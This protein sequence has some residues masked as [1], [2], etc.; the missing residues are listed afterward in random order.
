MTNH[1]ARPLWT[2][3]APAT[4]VLAALSLVTP[5]QAAAQFGAVETLARRVSDLSFYYSRGGATPGGALDDDPVG[6]TSFGVEL[7]FE[8]ARIPSPAARRRRAT[9]RPADRRVL[10]EVEVVRGEDGAVDSIFHYDVVRS[11]PG[12]G[13][14]DILWTLELGI[15]YGQV[16]GLEL[17]APGLDLNAMVRTLPSVTLYVSYEP[18]GTYLGLRTGFLRTYALQVV[19]GAGNVFPGKAEAFMMGGLMGYAIRIG[20]SYLFLE[21]GYTAR[22]F[23]SVEWNNTVP[24]PVGVPRSLD[25]SGWGLSVGIQF[26]VQ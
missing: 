16:Q 6:L 17:A 18:L 25:V 4:L 22:T 7:L 3:L 10:R 8:V 15:G 11:A 26:P 13:P 5:A 21:G 24:L 20:P 12:Y 2:G 19:D 1:P 9:Q 23:P 14:D